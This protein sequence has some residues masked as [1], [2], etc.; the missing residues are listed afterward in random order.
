MLVCNLLLAV[1]VLGAGGN[2]KMCGDKRSNPPVTRWPM[3][4]TNGQAEDR[5]V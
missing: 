2:P 1:I 4:F 5:A 3:I